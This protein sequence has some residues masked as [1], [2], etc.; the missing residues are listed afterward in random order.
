[1]KF[2]DLLD[3]NEA[4]SKFEA[5]V[6]D[7]V[8]DGLMTPDMTLRQ[9]TK[10]SWPIIEPARI[11]LS[12]WHIDYIA[13][14]LEAVDM[15]QIKR[16]NISMPP[17]MMKSITTV[18][19]FPAWLWTQKPWMWFMFI[20]Y[21]RELSAYHSKLR[22]DLLMS[23]WYQSRWGSVVYL[24]PDQNQK[25][26]YQNTA[27]GGMTSTSIGGT[28]TGKG[29]DI[30]VI[31]DGMNPEQ[32]ESEAD[33][34]TAINFVQKT[35]NT[36]LNDKVNGVIINIAQR[37]HKKD[38]TATL[39]AEG[40]W[41][42]VEL[43]AVAPKK[44]MIEFPIS[45]KVIERQEG[46][47][48]WPA[49]EPKEVID[50]QRR[51]MGARAFSAQ[52][53]QNPTLDESGFFKRENWKYYKIPPTDM[54]KT[55][56]LTAQSWDM[57]FKETKEG[58]FVCGLAGG[59][60]GMDFFLLDRFHNRS[61]FTAT[62]SAV[63]SFSSKWPMISA[64]VIE[65]KANGPAIISELKS[66]VGGLIPWQVEGS[67]AARAAAV[68]PYQEGGNV[69]LPDPSMPGCSWVHDFIEEMA[70]FPD[71]SMPDDQVDTFSQLLSYLLKKAKSS[72]PGVTVI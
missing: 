9:F 58:S 44:T 57:S 43:P 13:E 19:D 62:K 39:L 2:A 40:D 52:Y 26:E 32:S 68:S 66:V 72:G 54:V 42:N 11:F 56:K 30:I 14:H 1:M 50:R 67:K 8:A 61:N 21:S 7:I 55:L 41:V 23:T 24:S 36:R 49:R 45:K 70:G 12:N 20:S 51:V 18:I 17:R 22:R 64:K 34:E 31:D 60:K 47:I 59:S 38:I 48:L 35:V 65:D 6:F 29:A 3:R 16:L 63:V 10:E 4:F 33:R 46:E 5:G 15:G 25:T 71:P 28:V 37:L 53:Q 69:F 27:R